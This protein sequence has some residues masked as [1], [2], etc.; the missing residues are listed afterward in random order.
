MYLNL[1]GCFFSQSRHPR[2][3]YMQPSADRSVL[4]FAHCWHVNTAGNC[5]DLQLSFDVVSF[6]FLLPML[7]D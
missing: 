6:F 3:E 1:S 7:E 4:P 5:N 2:D